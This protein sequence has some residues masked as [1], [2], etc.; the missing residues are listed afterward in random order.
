[1]NHRPHQPP[2]IPPGRQGRARPRGRA[3]A[4]ASACT[5][6]PGALAR[7]HAPD[8]RRLRT[9]PAEPEIRV[10][11]GP[12]G[13]VDGEA[14]RRAVQDLTVRESRAIAYGVGN[15]LHVVHD[16][17]AEP[18]IEVAQ[19]LEYDP[20]TDVEGWFHRV[21]P[22]RTGAAAGPRP[23]ITR[24]SGVSVGTGNRPEGVFVHC[25]G[26]CAVN[27]GVVIAVRRVRTAIL[28][29]HRAGEQTREAMATLRR[30][31]RQSVSAIDVD[32]LV[33]D[34]LVARA[35]AGGQRHRGSGAAG[36]R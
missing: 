33:P 5:A 36:R 13:G 22:L 1:M 25:I 28:A 10:L 27:L 7:V 11:P 19:L 14:P 8:G 21:E 18:V 31:V 23:R 12:S 3:G 34:G 6:G 2:T 24:S 16:C 32:A 17:P 20:A 9:R 15:S 35:A 30:T 4:Q 26:E 29:Y